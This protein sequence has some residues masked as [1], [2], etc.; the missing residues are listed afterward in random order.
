VLLSVKTVLLLRRKQL[1]GDIHRVVDDMRRIIGEENALIIKVGAEVNDPSTEDAILVR[2]LSAEVDR[3]VKDIL[4]NVEDA[5]D[6]LILSSYVCPYILSYVF[7][8]TW[9]VCSWLSSRLIVTMWVAS[10]APRVRVS[11]NFVT[12]SV[13]KSTSQMMATKPKTR[14]RK[15]RGRPISRKLRCGRLH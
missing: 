2:G 13:S 11:T 15:E 1:P 8:L 5:K 12:R 3:A 6:D 9:P 10:S 14:V 4:K 7:Q